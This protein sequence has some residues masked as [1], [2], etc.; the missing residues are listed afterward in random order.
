M[1]K[2]WEEKKY[3]TRGMEQLVKSD[4]EAYKWENYQI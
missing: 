1:W 4:D 3:L 2:A